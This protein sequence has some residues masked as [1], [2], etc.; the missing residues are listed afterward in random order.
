MT[1][2]IHHVCYCSTARCLSQHK[3]QILAA[4]ANSLDLVL[5]IISTVHFLTSLYF[6]SAAGK[7]SWLHHRNRLL[8]D[9][10]RHV[11]YA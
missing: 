2:A 3:G 6:S 1:E 10:H 11:F 5:F 8:I 7:K 4:Q 9:L